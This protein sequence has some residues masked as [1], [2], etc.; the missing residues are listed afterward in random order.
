MQSDSSALNQE[1]ASA[2]RLVTQ[3]GRSEMT[4]MPELGGALS[5][6]CLWNERQQKK[7]PSCVPLITDQDIAA[8]NPY[9]KG[10]LLYPFVNRLQD[11]VYEFQGN[12]F[13]FP[14]N[15]PSTKTALHGF[16][17]NR[18]PDITVTDASDEEIVVKLAFEH[19]SSFAPYPFDGR[20]TVTYRLSD[21]DGFSVDFL[22][23]NLGEQAMPVAVGWH[24]YF[25]LPGA[26]A[27]WQLSLAD[28]KMVDVDSRLLPTGELASFEGFTQLHPLGEIRL[29]N[30]FVL[31]KKAPI[32]ITRLW[33]PVSKSGL[34]IWQQTQ[35]AQFNYLQLCIP[36][37]R[38]AI[39]IEPVTANINAFNNNQGLITLKPNAQ[40]QVRCG[41][42]C[43]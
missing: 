30:C 40:Y 10:V 13:S 42:R 31:T 17:F 20:L 27:D 7:M 5:E 19:D 38:D 25:C 35:D 9:Y 34:S 24:P 28:V 11:G 33:S 32:Q 1:V 39:A 41:V 15:E 21:N 26:L 23:E 4:L 3:T 43:E 22:V 37:T 36:P 18:K 2:L 8:G 29:D 6:L 14:V 16:V 12:K